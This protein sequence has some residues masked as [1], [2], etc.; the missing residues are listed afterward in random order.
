MAKRNPLPSQS[1][2]Q[3]CFTYNP[4]TG[5]LIWN[6]RPQHHFSAEIVQ[7]QVNTRHAGNIAG[8]QQT[9]P[10]TGK[11]YI[12]ILIKGKQYQAS[13]I[14][15]KMITNCEYEDIDHENG[16][17]T[18]NRLHNLRPCTHVDNVKNK[19][20]YHHNKSGYKGVSYCKE[21]RGYRAQIQVR[22][23]GYNAGPFAT[24]EE[25]SEAY[26]QLSA[27]FHGEFGRTK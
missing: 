12:C 24:P 6:V 1:Y 17:S 20:M 4:W 3:E 18:N 10:Y 13:R 9:H 7:R 26:S 11:T 25:A 8:T 22:G 15:I 27:K 2:L 19:R 23:K 21:L 16:D 14:I 5:N